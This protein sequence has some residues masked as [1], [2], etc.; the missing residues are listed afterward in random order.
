MQRIA[1]CSDLVYRDPQSMLSFG[2]HTGDLIMVTVATGNLRQNEH[3]SRLEIARW[4]CET[5]NG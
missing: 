5:K 2:Y 3:D 4:C 1:N